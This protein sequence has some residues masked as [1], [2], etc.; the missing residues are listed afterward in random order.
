MHQK[1]VTHQQNCTI[2]ENL[3]STK[4]KPANRLHSS[5]KYFCFGLKFQFWHKVAF[6]NINSISISI[7]S[8]KMFVA[9]NKALCYF[10]CVVNFKCNKN[11]I[12]FDF[13]ILH[14]VNYSRF[15]ILPSTLVIQSMRTGWTKGALALH[16]QILK[17]KQII[18]KCG[19]W[20]FTLIAR[21]HYAHC[22]VS[23]R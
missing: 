8:R 22:K 10:E 5:D 7:S 23:K 1:L 6:W 17:Q 9:Y 2:K 19:Y 13:L 14:F 20:C 12:T 16:I 18:L 11:L 21:K 3:D 4:T 15:E